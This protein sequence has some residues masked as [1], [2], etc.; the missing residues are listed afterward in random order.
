MRDVIRNIAGPDLVF[1]I[2]VLPKET[3]CQRLNK[4]HGEGEAA[5]SMT[6]F[7]LKLN[8]TYEPAGDDEIN[9]YNVVITTEMSTE[10]VHDEIMKVVSKL[11]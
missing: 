2:L 5:K 1:I 9:A 10:N 11:K 8:D 4:R 6:E 3:I 7:C